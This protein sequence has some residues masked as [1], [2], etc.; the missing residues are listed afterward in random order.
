M[1]ATW[2]HM[3][4]NVTVEP[5]LLVYFMTVAMSQTAGLNLLLQK[6]CHPNEAPKGVDIECW[7]EAAA[8]DMVTKINTW[9]PIL[10]NLVPVLFV[11][12]AGPWS[13]S[14]G[15][16]RPLMFLPIVGQ[17]LTDLGILLNIYYWTWPPEVTAV[18][19]CIFYGITGGKACLF[20]GVISYISDITSNQQRTARLGVITA[21]FFVGTPI[22]AGL[23][24][25]LRSLIGFYGV[26]LFSIFC[27]LL[28]LQ[29]GYIL[30]TN[31]PRQHPPAKT[32]A[33]DG[34]VDP[35]EIVRSVKTVFRKRDG[36]ERFI[37][38]AMIVISTMTACP[39]HG[40]YSVLLFYTRYKFHWNEVTYGMYVL[41]KMVVILIGTAFAMGLLSRCLKVR[42]SI[43][44]LAACSTLVIA[45]T[46]NAFADQAWELYFYPA[47]DMMHGAGVAVAKSIASKIVLNNELG[48]LNSV[49]AVS[50]NVI[51]LGIYP[52]YNYV[53]R[54]TFQTFAGSFFLLSAVMGVIP[55]VLF[56]YV[57]LVEPA[58][59]VEKE[60]KKS[61]PTGISIIGDSLKIDST[62]QN[63]TP[64]KQV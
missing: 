61:P 41:Y 10:Q 55:L 4:K 37:I 47:V 26:F 60:P 31:P 11:V 38:L 20:I 35:N 1:F 34:L 22:G 5:M 18:F 57:F 53:Y 64:E 63:A 36:Y 24:G 40:E 28:S 16:R 33:W 21:I 48:Q 54:Q 62:Q 42:D 8:Q 45:A 23:S 7:D 27:D 25:F 50:E 52:L 59:F 30:I 6:A 14:H 15:R 49:M 39:A 13:D 12:F 3:L 2:R 29:L 51:V 43:I 44:G 46:G 17:V 32:S 9:K 19:E 58:E 56:I